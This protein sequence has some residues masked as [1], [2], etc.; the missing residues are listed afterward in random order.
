M[1]HTLVTGGAG[2]IGSHL[3]DRLLGRGDHVVVVDNFLTGRYANLTHLEGHPRLSIVHQDLAQPFSEGVIP[4]PFDR[5]FNLAS[6]ASP[7]GYGK[8]PIETQLVN[9]IGA[10]HVLRIAQ[11]DNARFLQASTSEVYGDP[12]VHPQTEEYWGNV[13]PRGPRA[14]YDEGKRFA[15]SLLMEFVR[16][17]DLD[18][19]TA[20][21]F[22]TYGPRSHPA[23]GRV[24]PSFCMQALRGEP[25]TI[26]GDGTQTRSFCYV[27]DLVEGLIR[28]MDEEGL[29]G[30]VINLGNPTEITV[31]QFADI[32]IKVTNSS[33]AVVYEPL[34]TDDPTRRQPDIT[35][36]RNR[37]GW[38][39]KV[40]LEEG[41]VPTVDYFRAFA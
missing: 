29:K 24:V 19:R 7:K 17:H 12:L 39:P 37:L 1:L 14:C 8:Y 36:A 15:E 18:A 41:L 22:N 35:R 3:V 10:L 32:V 28:L 20:R 34:P 6:P 40:P 38:E 21:I 2:F 16:Q 30:E 25:L 33:S 11:R 31:A 4:G 9:S 27:D 13:N 26:F 23:D 5:V